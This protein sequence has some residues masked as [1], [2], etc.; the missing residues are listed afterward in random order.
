MRF[1]SNILTRV[2][3]SAALGA[4]GLNDVWIEKFSEHHSRKR[5]KGYEIRLAADHAKGRRRRNSGQYGADGSE[6][7]AATYSEHGKW[8]AELYKIDPE[9]IVAGC[10]YDINSFNEQTRYEFV[11]LS[12]IPY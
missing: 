6:V 7:W 11:P 9:M 3:F 10:Y 2:D 4:A 8:M 1:H 5:Q 12:S